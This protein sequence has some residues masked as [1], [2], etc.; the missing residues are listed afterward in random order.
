MA[1]GITM[2]TFGG[3][4]GGTNLASV[5]T[6]G[7]GSVTSLTL[8]PGA[9]ITDNSFGAI[10]DGATGMTVIKTGQGTQVL[11][12]NNS[13]SG[14]TTISGGVL[15]LGS[16][17]A[18]GTGGVAVNSGGTLDLNGTQPIFPILSGN[19]VIGNSSTGGFAILNYDNSTTSATFSGTIQNTVGAGTNVVGLYV[20]SGT[21]TLSGASTYT[22]A[23]TVDVGST[24]LLGP[25]GLLGN[26]ALSVENIA[27]FGTA[28]TA[29][30]GTATMGGSL[31]L[32]AGSTLDFIDAFTN[33]LHAAAASVNAANLKFDLIGA[34]ND[35]LSLGGALTA[36]GISTISFSTSGSLA[37][38]YIL[39]NFANTTATS[40]NFT[41]SGLAGYHVVVNAT[42][43]LLVQYSVG[44]PSN[45]LSGSGSWSNGGNW[46][47]GTPNLAAAGAVINAPSSSPI[48][49]T[50]DE[51]VTLGT[52]VLSNTNSAAVTLTGTGANA[53]TLNNSG[54]AATITI[55][56]G[57]HKI[58]A[59][60]VLDDG[61]QA[62]I[63][64]GTL[65]VGEASNISGT[66]P[67]TMGNAGGS[68]IL[69]GSDGYSGSTIVDAGTLVL[70]SSAALP[71]ESIL[72]VSAGGTVIFD[73][74]LAVASPVRL[75]QGTEVVSPVPEPETLVLLIAELVVGMAGWR[76]R[77]CIRG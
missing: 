74:A 53:L 16:N 9:G 19:G 29:G 75:S 77:N 69:S 23:T 52:L 55:T 50:L 72:T 25:G 33:T 44:G 36:S 63:S 65:A 61:L 38:S 42:G 34:G 64:G 10:D 62:S 20:G 28:L 13:Y 40:S 67:L 57:G 56:Q 8:N 12:G 39:A 71:T 27:T 49:V 31:Y 47:G 21:L 37:S 70:T 17:S 22:R 4:N 48:T 73:P 6:T 3:L 14:G 30:G 66:G 46:S 43:L 24:L 2:P 54:S 58:D 11:S 51:P 32:A 15:E 18:L 26:T 1:S 60:V 59:Q 35:V 5:I 76:G 7:Y 41:I 68:L 45:W